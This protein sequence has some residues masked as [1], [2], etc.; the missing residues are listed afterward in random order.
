MQNYRI[1]D[2]A[3]VSP[4]TL[5]EAREHLQ[6]YGDGSYDTY[7]TSLLLVADEVVN[8]IIGEPIG[9]TEIVAWYQDFNNI[10]LP[11]RY[12]TQVDSVQ[13]YDDSNVLQ[14]V[15]TSVYFFDQ[16]ARLP[17]VVL[18]NG[19]SWPGPNTSTRRDPVLVNYQVSVNAFA[20]DDIEH[21]ILLV[22]S[23]LFN[24]RS[25]TMEKPSHNVYLTAE[26]LLQRYRT[27]R[28]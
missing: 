18:N 20:G 26:A 23:D 10:E 15:D 21:A 27:F 19:Q 4:V 25:S 17:R 9:V 5:D 11:H 7:L 14:T 28:W 8:S 22:L 16:N 6:L 3:T 1:I 24:S 2:R 12:A 13:Y